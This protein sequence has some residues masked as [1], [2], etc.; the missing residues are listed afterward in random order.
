VAVSSGVALA[1]SAGKVGW[2]ASGEGVSSSEVA[3]QP[4]SRRLRSR[5]V[6]RMNLDVFLM[7]VTIISRKSLE[8]KQDEKDEREEG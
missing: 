8:D 1:V 6:Y 3:A 7:R 4:E 5:K 2:V